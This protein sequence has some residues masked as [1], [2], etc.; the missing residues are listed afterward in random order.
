[1]GSR[2]SALKLLAIDLG[3]WADRQKHERFPSP[4]EE[5]TPWAAPGS[6]AKL[7]NALSA[8]D[9]ALVGKRELRAQSFEFL[10]RVLHRGSLFTWE[11]GEFLLCRRMDQDKRQ[12]LS[13]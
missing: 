4:R 5:P 9:G 3:L 7:A 1:L 6:G 12:S 13:F 11:R 10:Q 8:A 2:N